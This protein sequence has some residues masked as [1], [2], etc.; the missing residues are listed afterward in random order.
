MNDINIHV[1][2]YIQV[3]NYIIEKINDNTF[4]PGDKIYSEKELKEKFKISSTT[5]V[6]A[7]NEL[8]N[9]GYL[10]RIQGK[11]SFVST[12]KLKRTPLNLSITEELRS[13]GIDL[14]TNLLSI[15]EVMEPKISLKLGKKEDTTLCKI[16]RLRYIQK[17]NSTEPIVVQVSYIPNDFVSM[18]DLKLFE[19][20]NSLYKILYQTRNLKPY[21]AKETYSVD[22]IKKTNI[23]K[24]LEQK[25]GD[26]TFFVQR[27]TYTKD[28]VP[29]EYA[30]SYLRWDRYTLEVEVFDTSQLD[31]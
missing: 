21:R 28:E 20:E 11:G 17:N 27:I 23:A 3:K 15:E 24:L 2:L 8:V 6:K 30:E 9:E 10:D 26:P 4:N 5:V 7:L 31:K 29:F 14:L 22:L 12:P 19:T 13:K 1:P 25:C 18:D 16:S